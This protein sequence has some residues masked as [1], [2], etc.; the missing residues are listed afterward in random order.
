ML[1]GLTP[2]ERYVLA[3]SFTELAIQNGLFIATDDPTENALQVTTFFDTVAENLDSG[4]KS[5]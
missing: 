1:L 3:K 4:K 5:E 2:K